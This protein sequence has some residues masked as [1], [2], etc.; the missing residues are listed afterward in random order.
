M[1]GLFRTN[2]KLPST[3]LMV[4]ARL[5]QEERTSCPPWGGDSYVIMHFR[6]HGI[7][8]KTVIKRGYF[9]SNGNIGVAELSPDEDVKRRTLYA[10]L[11]GHLNSHIQTAALSFNEEGSDTWQTRID[12][13][14]SALFVQCDDGYIGVAWSEA[15]GDAQDAYSMCTFAA[16]ALGY[17]NGRDTKLRVNSKKLLKDKAKTM[18]TI[19]IEGMEAALKVQNLTASTSNA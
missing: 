2:Y 12:E 11:E 8:P 16:Y 3:E 4:A 9:P 19:L 15:Q 7:S 13:H 18:A 5:E 17:Y 1:A 6:D 10:A 14:S